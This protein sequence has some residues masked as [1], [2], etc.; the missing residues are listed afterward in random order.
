VG[1]LIKDALG[2]VISTAITDPEGNCYK[3][4]LGEI[5]EFENESG[6]MEIVRN[7]AQLSEN[8]FIMQDELTVVTW[9]ACGLLAVAGFIAV[10]TLSV[11]EDKKSNNN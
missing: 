10:Y 2:R 4:I 3:N 11:M 7:T 5:V 1:G 8:G 9:V 6:A